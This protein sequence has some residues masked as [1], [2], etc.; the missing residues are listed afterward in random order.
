MSRKT[1]IKLQLNSDEITLN[2]CKESTRTN[3]GC[4]LLV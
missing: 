3:Q 1:P 2:E 4:D